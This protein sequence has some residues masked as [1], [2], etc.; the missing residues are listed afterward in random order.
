VSSG[1]EYVLYV[2]R[3]VQFATAMLVFGGSTFRFYGLDVK[4]ATVGLIAAFDERLRSVAL[5]AAVLA[6]VSGFVLLLCQAAAMTSSPAAALDLAT[7]GAVLSDTRFGHV[8]S[9]HLL[10]ALILVVACLGAP[11][12]RNTAISGLSLEW[13]LRWASTRPDDPGIT[14]IQDAIRSFSQI[15]YLAIAFIAVSGAINSLLMVGG[16]GALIQTPYGRLLAVKISL[17][18]EMVAIAL[19]NRLRLAPRVSADPAAFGILYRTV[20]LEQGLGYA[21]SSPSAFSELCRRRS[22][23]ATDLCSTGLVAPD[24]T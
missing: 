2:C 12:W 22:M 5:A 14:T 18:L 3:A 11:S 17:L 6:L 16:L 4:T 20:T 21:F 1:V 19:I 10:I 7:V 9:Y 24:F 15:G 8:W 13:C 23:S